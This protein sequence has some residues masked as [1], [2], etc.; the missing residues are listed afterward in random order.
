MV[1]TNLKQKCFNHTEY[2]ETH[3]EYFEHR[4][5]NYT[6]VLE[7]VWGV[8]DVMT[9]HSRNISRSARVVTRILLCGSRG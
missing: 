9:K 3:F 6:T 5:R 1:E 2:N 4:G 7:K 8:D